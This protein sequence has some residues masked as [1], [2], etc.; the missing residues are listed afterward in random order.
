MAGIILRTSDAALLRSAVSA[1]QRRLRAQDEPGGVGPTGLGILARL[2]RTGVANA[3]EIAQQEHLQPQSLTRSLKSLHDAGLIDRW[4]DEDDR[5]RT[6]LAITPKGEELLKG[7]IRKRIMWLARVMNSR[8]SPQERETLRAAS[9][10]IERIAG[11]GDPGK[12]S[13]IV[14]NLAP[15]TQVADVSR[16]L[17]FYARLG[18][19]EDGRFEHEGRLVW[20]SMHGRAVRAARIMFALADAPIDPN[21]QGV[22]FYCWSDNIASLVERLTAAGL[23]PSSITHPDHM[24]QGE[25]QIGDPDGYVL[26]IGQLTRA[27]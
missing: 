26:R 22:G 5:R 8:L 19:V 12:T 11:G 24:P 23:K 13:D 16:S 27:R 20:A 6:S 3:S 9:F 10:L 18:F 21:A 25:F 7:T 1:L 14:I 17:E 4:T 2:F 15:E